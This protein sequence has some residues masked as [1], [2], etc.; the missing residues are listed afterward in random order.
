MK[1]GI[2]VAVA[3]MLVGISTPKMI[4]AENTNIETCIVQEE[5]EYNKIDIDQLPADIIS[6]VQ[7]S[8]KE[9]TIENAFVG[10]DGSYKLVVK[11]DKKMSLVYFSKDGKFIKSEPI[12]S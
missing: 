10:T 8:F 9:S 11:E 2:I 1:K 5:V 7:Q 6:A 3:I 4:F 12:K